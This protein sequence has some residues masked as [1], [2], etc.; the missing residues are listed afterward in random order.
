MLSLLVFLGLKKGQYTQHL[1]QSTTVT[2]T[3]V[4]KVRLRFISALFGVLA[5]D[6][7]QVCSSKQHIAFLSYLLGS[8]SKACGETL[9]S[10]MSLT[11][12]QNIFFLC[13]V[14]SWTTKQP[15]RLFGNKKVV[16]NCFSLLDFKVKAYRGTIYLLLFLYVTI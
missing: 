2:V 12:G 3:F 16:N 1:P 7:V 10:Q 8:D 5:G 13:D 6:N 14:L 9:S 15:T 11:L 4:L